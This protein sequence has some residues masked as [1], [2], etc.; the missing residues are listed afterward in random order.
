MLASVFCSNESALRESALGLSLM[1]LLRASNLKLVNFAAVVLARPP[2]LSKK[3]EC[4]P[5]SEETLD[6]LGIRYGTDK[7]SRGHPVRNHG[8]LG[9][10]ERFLTPLRHEPLRILEIGVWR[11]QSLMMWAEYFQ[12]ARV[13][14]ST[15]RP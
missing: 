10:Y 12:N 13:V 6:E 5:M 9:F 1:L 14:A 11:G 15:P 8:Y 3:P 4:A 7:A 2:E